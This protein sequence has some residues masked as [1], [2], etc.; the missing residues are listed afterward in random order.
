MKKKL[1]K[2]QLTFSQIVE[3]CYCGKDCTLTPEEL[4]IY[5]KAFLFDLRE[6]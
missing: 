6:K 3:V 5:I 1:K 4:R 2:Y